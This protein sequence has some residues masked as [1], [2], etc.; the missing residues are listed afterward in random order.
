MVMA[1]VLMTFR[2]RVQEYF[3]RYLH[4]C[5]AT[6]I[7]PWQSHIPIR[8]EYIFRCLIKILKRK[9]ERDEREREKKER[10]RESIPVNKFEWTNNKVLKQSQNSHDGTEHFTIKANLDAALTS[11]CIKVIILET[12]QLDKTLLI[13]RRA[14]VYLPF[15]FSGLSHQFWLILLQSPV[16]W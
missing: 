12:G 8:P 15:A 5:F 7:F 9:K 4:L 6:F 11:W 13:I 16:Q 2:T 14:N 3:Y 10:E 1:E